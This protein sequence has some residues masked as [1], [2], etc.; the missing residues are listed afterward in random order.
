M[1]GP[2]HRDLNQDNSILAL[3]QHAGKLPTSSVA[4]SGGEMH[5][6]DSR[7]YGVSRTGEEF[8]GD[9]GEMSYG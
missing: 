7:D 3:A 5:V 6:R 2:S 1:P 4:F 8:E 9:D